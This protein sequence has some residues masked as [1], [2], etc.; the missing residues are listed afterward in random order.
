MEK[1]NEPQ[2]MDFW[3]LDD[4]LRVSVKYEKQDGDLKDNVSLSIYESC[5]EDEKLFI[6]DETNMY[7][8]KEEAILLANA[9]LNAVRHSRQDQ[10]GEAPGI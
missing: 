1:K 8:T 7:L 2:K 10:P 6:A 4:T 5:P 3:I 9:L